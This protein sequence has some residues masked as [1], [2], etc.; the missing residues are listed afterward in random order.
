[1]YGASPR[2]T[3]HVRPVRSSTLPR[4]I[5]RSLTAVR[6]M[7]SPSGVTSSEKPVGETWTS[8]RPVSIARSRLDA[9]CW[10]CRMVPV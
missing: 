8:H 7:T 3:Y 9:T 6:S 4:T 5:A 1:M 10:L 2:F